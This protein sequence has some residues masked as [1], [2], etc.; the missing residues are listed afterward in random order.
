MCAYFLN[1]ARLDKFLNEG[2]RGA[3]GGQIFLLFAFFAAL[4]NVSTR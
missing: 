3:I 4:G 2:F 1:D